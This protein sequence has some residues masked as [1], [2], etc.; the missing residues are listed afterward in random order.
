LTL[1]YG[2]WFKFVKSYHLEILCVCKYFLSK[3]T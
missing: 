2:K 1:A 3:Q